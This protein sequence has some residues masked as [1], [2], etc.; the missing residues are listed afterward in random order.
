[1]SFFDTFVKPI[2]KIK[3]KYKEL[4]QNEITEY[5]DKALKKILI[6]WFKAEPNLSDNIKQL[7]NTIFYQKKELN[8]NVLD[9]E[10]KRESTKK[11][12]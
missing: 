3:E 8:I 11:I 7:L 9:T 6:E 1:M 12:I 10:V 4:N 5:L 2:Y